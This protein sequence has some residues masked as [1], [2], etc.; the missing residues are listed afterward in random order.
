M[1]QETG[2]DAE[3]LIFKFLFVFW[4]ELT[5]SNKEVFHDRK[6]TCHSSLTD[7]LQGNEN[8]F[9]INPVSK[10]QTIRAFKWN[11]MFHLLDARERMPFELYK[12]PGYSSVEA[13]L[14][15]S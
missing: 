14:P 3:E 5:L 11:Y 10:Q 12:F 1:E 9:P 15:R 6:L 13:I 8:N 7:T 4:N 2:N